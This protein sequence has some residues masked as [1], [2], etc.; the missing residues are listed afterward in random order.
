MKTSRLKSVSLPLRLMIWLLIIPMSVSAVNLEETKDATG[1]PA[2]ELTGQS[3]T[4]FHFGM[5]RMKL[6][7]MPQYTD[8]RA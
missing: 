5:D 8:Y 7:L 6:S 1:K 4:F 3:E 2:Q